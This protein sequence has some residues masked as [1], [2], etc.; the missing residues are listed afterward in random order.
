M[1]ISERV[2]AYARPDASKDWLIGARV[3]IVDHRFFIESPHGRDDE[4]LIDN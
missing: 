3:E 2:A 1:P 4:A